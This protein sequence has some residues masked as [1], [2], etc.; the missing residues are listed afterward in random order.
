MNLAREG[1]TLIELL[2]VISIIALLSTVIL[3]SVTAQKTRAK[4]VAF[5]STVKSIQAAAGICC[6]ASTSSLRNTLG[7]DL[8]NP[9]SG[10][11]YPT[12]ANIGSVEIIRDCHSIDGF[13][14]K[15][16]PG[17]S[18]RGNVI[19]YALCDRDDCEYIGY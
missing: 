5:Q 9:A 4:D 13:S 3:S 17:T 10:S 1:F 8:C 11:I 15:I 19:E 18:N 7:E 12:G 2:V 6:N 14:M 16:F